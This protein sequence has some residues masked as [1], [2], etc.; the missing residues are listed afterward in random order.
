MNSKALPRQVSNTDV[1]V[2]ECEIHLKFRLIEEKSILG[3]DKD[4]LLQILLDALT[5]G[6]DDF[7]E[8]LHTLVKAHEVSEFKASP[9]MRRQLMRLRNS[10]DTC[11]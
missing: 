11:P 1:S 8:T 2:Y 10:A 3:N 4:Q 6:S 7:L 9:Q 5:E